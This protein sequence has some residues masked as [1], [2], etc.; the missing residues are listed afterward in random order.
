[1]ARNGKWFA[2]VVFPA[3]ETP[4]FKGPLRPMRPYSNDPLVDAR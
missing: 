2:V 1:M 3:F 4:D